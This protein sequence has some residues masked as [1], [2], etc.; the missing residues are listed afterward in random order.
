M[1]P[2]SVPTKIR[3]FRAIARSGINPGPLNEHPQRFR[4]HGRTH[5]RKALRLLS[6]MEAGGAERFPSH[7][8]SNGHDVAEWAEEI[9]SGSSLGSKL[10]QGHYLCR[11]R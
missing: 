9:L 5:V 7:P 11:I 2:Q 8:G 1:R 6:S 3:L 4:H 10:L